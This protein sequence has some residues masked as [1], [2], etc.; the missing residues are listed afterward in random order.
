LSQLIGDATAADGILDRLLHKCAKYRDERQF[1]EQGPWY[2][3]LALTELL[4]RRR[5]E[6][7]PP[8]PLFPLA[9]LYLRFAPDGSA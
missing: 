1:H 4:Q 3:E 8:L 7:M 2:G 9:A 5:G 6:A